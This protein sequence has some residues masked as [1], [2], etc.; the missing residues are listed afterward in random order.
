MHH[1]Y[2][3]KNRLWHLP[4]RQFTLKYQLLIANREQVLNK[5]AVI[6]FTLLLFFSTMLW[7]LAN[8]SLN[9]YLASQITLQGNYY[10]GQETT[11]TQADFA[12]DSG[13]ATFKGI[14]LVNIGHYQAKNALTIDEVSV[15][16]SPTQK[17]TMLTAVHKVTV[18]KLTL[19]IEKNSKGTNIE[20][21]INSITTKLAN[22]YPQQYPQV[23]AKL[24]AESHP[25]LNAVEYKNEHPQA[26]P[27]IEHTKDKKTRGKP[28]QKIKI[29]TILIKNLVINSIES[30][31]SKTTNINN[32][33]LAAIGEQ[34][35]LSL[36]QIGGEILLRLLRANH[37]R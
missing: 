16:L 32:V 17:Q 2:N 30:G 36:N 31:V 26:G 8:S 29:S 22:D 11:I 27:I 23:S 21:I 13:I 24:Y 34:E 6:A 12:A 33:N 28:Q 14:S 15:E 9:E 5:L 19:N 7:Y 3:V 18:N 4:Y 20:Q 25:N 35:G 10:T 37:A 1:D